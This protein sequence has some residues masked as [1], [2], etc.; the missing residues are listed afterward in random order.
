MGTVSH[1]ADTFGGQ[2]EALVVDRFARA[3]D[4]ELIL[5]RFARPTSRG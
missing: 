3:A 2:L 5:R 4:D 1:A